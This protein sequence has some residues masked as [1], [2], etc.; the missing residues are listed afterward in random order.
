M[1]LPMEAEKNTTPILLITQRKL[2]PIR[3]QPR[4]SLYKILNR[5]SQMSRQLLYILI[6]QQHMP[7]PTTTIATARA[8]KPR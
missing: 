5:Q 1:D 2:R 4:I 8:H 3:S 6:P 7:R